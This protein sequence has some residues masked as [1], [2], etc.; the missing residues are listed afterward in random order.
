MN[1]QLLTMILICAT[2][3][4]PSRAAGLNFEVPFL[5]D[6]QVKTRA[7][8]TET[9][10]ADG[11]RLLTGLRLVPSGAENVYIGIDRST[12]LRVSLNGTT[13]NESAAKPELA[14]WSMGVAY[15]SQENQVLLV[16]LG[17]EGFMYSRT[18]AGVWS[19][20]KS[21][22]N[23]DL[24]SLVYNPADNTLYGIEVYGG[25]PGQPA[26]LLKFSPATG[27]KVGEVA[28]PP[29][30][31]DMRPGGHTAELI[32]V[33]GKIVALLERDPQQIM[34]AGD[35][36]RIYVIDPSTGAAE[37]TY[38]NEPGHNPTVAFV[39]PEN[40]SSVKVNEAITLTIQASD[41]DNDLRFLILRE[42]PAELKMWSLDPSPVGIY[43][44]TYSYTP[45]ATGAHTLEVTVNDLSGRVAKATLTLNA[46]NPPA[47]H[48]PFAGI[49]NPYSD[50][51]APRGETLHID[52]EA[53]DED[54][55]LQTATLSYGGTILK[56]WTF[57]NATGSQ[58]LSY[59]FVP[60][61]LGKRTLKLRVTD[62]AGNVTEDSVEVTVFEEPRSF[63][64]WYYDA[65]QA[66]PVHYTP[67]GPVQPGPLYRGLH[68]AKSNPYRFLGRD[69][70]DVFLWDN[71]TAV[72]T[73]T[74]P[75]GEL[76]WPRG[77]AYDSE[78]EHFLVVSLGGEGFLYS[79]DPTDLEWNI[80]ASME[81]LDVD[82][83]EYHAADDH[84]YMVEY[85][86]GAVRILRYNALGKPEGQPISL[87]NVPL[88][89]GG[90]YLSRLISTGDKLALLIEPTASWPVTGPVESRIY[91]IDPV[92]QTGA[93][94]Y[95]K[96]WET[97]PPNLPPPPNTAPVVQFKQ[98]AGDISVS[99]SDVVNVS[100][101]VSDA[102]NDLRNATL[103]LGGTT[104]K[105][106]TFEN[107]T[108]VQTLTF[109]FTAQQLGSRPLSLRATDS[110]G[111]N[112]EVSVQL[113]VTDT[114][115][116]FVGWYH[117]NEGVVAVDYTE[118]GPDDGGTL[119]RGLPVAQAGYRYLGRDGHTIFR[120]DNEHD[121]Y[122]TTSPAGEFSWPRGTTWDHRRDRFL[123]VTLG[124]E[125]FLYAV[126]PVTLAW[127][128]I[129]S[130]DNVDVDSIVYHHVDDRIY[131]VENHGG[132]VRILKY[133]AQ[134][135]RLADAATIANVP[136]DIGS[137]YQSRLISAGDKLA[138][139]IEPTPGWRPNPP[140]ESRI[141]I[142]NPT[143]GASELTYRKIW[144]TWPP[145]PTPPPPP[146]AGV[147][148]ERDLPASYAPEVV[149]TVRLELKPT[150]SAIAWAVEEQAPA[151]WTFGSASDSGV[152]DRV[153]GKIKW[154]PFTDAQPRTLTYTIRP[155]AGSTG[156]K[157]FSGIVSFNGTSTPITGD[158]TISSAPQHHPA[159]APP[160]DFRITVNELTAYA[161]AWKTGTEWPRGPS[162]IP[163]SYV[164]RAGQIWKSGE[165]YQY[166]GT[167]APPGCWAPVNQYLR[168]APLAAAALPAA[169]EITRALPP[170][171]T[172]GRL[173]TV[174]VTVRPAAG[175]NA[176]AVEERPPAGWTIASAD[177]AAIANGAVRYGPFFDSEPRTFTYQIVP[178]A[179]ASAEF[180][181]A[182]SFDGSDDSVKGACAVSQSGCAA[183]HRDGRVYLSI[184]ATPGE[185]FVLESATSIDSAT[186]TLE[187]N[188]Q[189]AQTAVELPAI[190]P[191]AG[192]KFYRLRPVA[193]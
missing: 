161:A 153:T 64:A 5:V 123:V 105:T 67:E 107:A 63:V 68:V 149:L 117:K 6:G 174:S 176:Y 4:I 118:K 72:Y 34:A 2:T 168:T 46:T 9:G 33:E 17:G 45:R 192:S 97:W 59:N 136:L 114:A 31:V 7:F 143:T 15:D 27:E 54:N 48:A 173:T 178:A 71:E 32:A 141:Y 160:Q 102:E 95:R 172:P 140:V 115:V 14:D 112:I 8:N 191:S 1:C 106:W 81:N 49:R 121:T 157:T 90:P 129:A 186:W 88:S 80:I 16:T 24:E 42:E 74:A 154:G 111:H 94:T 175:V 79:V 52:A 124:G 142:I 76:S 156:T 146:P 43:T 65:G 182:G 61:E 18:P 30:P 169:S 166:V 162:P 125:G 152:I 13:V 108:G 77:A 127:T 187:S 47:S 145:Q 184:N 85:A 41:P 188:I 21:M 87:P 75:A 84:L 58:T 104:L 44:T 28:L 138:L 23:I 98:P 100:V 60:N 69:G 91:M 170:A 183:E 165:T 92:A 39:S 99:H 103:L 181:G 12:V 101:E 190:E 78:R 40:G 50:T 11:K 150:P 82:S 135:N 134:G 130:M 3:L 83:I 131:M 164:T 37:L 193:Q 66:F 137:Y 53:S 86:G 116:R 35:H 122:T 29:F 55:D 167:I 189:G 96:V 109:E 147:I 70:H 151:G 93:L 126:N 26:R 51:L 25:S 132:T 110:A 179:T 120:Y 155:N 119:Y 20:V 57:E 159:D 22:N 177:G 144:D 139:L 128:T 180:S 56:T 89:L 62:A 133:D 185:Q 36:S 38:D 73:P 19:T 163:I 113:T 171:F 148:V 158:T 10:P